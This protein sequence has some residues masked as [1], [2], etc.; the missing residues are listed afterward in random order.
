MSRT[1]QRRDKGK[2]IKKT[3]METTL[4][5]RISGLMDEV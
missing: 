2:I 5:G 3:I 4:C 1:Y